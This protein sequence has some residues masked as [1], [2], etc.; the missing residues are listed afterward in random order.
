MEAE[1]IDKDQS[2]CKQIAAA[3]FVHTP[4]KIDLKAQEVSPKQFDVTTTLITSTNN[5]SEHVIWS[6]WRRS[7]QLRVWSLHK[8]SQQLQN[9]SKCGLV[10][11]NYLLT[12]MS[13]RLSKHQSSLSSVGQWSWRVCREW[14]LQRRSVTAS[15]PRF[16]LFVKGGPLC[17][18]AGKHTQH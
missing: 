10:L 4:E 1:H 11:Q 13:L 5:D 2:T 9:H 7:D 3:K 14:S 8:T 16:V 6:W 15:E 17:R 12:G 18:M